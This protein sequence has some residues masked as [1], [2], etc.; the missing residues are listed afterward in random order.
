MVYFYENTKMKIKIPIKYKR[1][2]KEEV[3]D[4]LNKKRPK[5]VRK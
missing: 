4:I 1:K 3:K 5:R 2:I